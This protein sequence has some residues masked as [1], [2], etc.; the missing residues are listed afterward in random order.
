MSNSGTKGAEVVYALLKSYADASL[1]TKNGDTALDLA[2][3]F[4]N[5]D[6]AALLAQ[7]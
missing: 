4:R 5:H 3:R 7:E 1:Q 2:I 6:A